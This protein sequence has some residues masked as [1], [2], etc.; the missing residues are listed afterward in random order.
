RISFLVSRAS[1]HMARNASL[2]LRSSVRSLLRNRFLASCCV[3]EEPP[4]TTPP[5][6]VLATSAR[7]AGEIDS[8][9]FV[10]APVLSRQHGLDQMIG[11]LVER[12]RVI[13]PDAA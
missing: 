13:M 10:E 7:G 1:S 11:K 12:D 9:M 3:M 6:L 8:E 2:T 4:C 5:A